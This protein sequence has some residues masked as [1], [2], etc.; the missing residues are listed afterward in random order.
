MAMSGK[1]RL[2]SEFFG[3]IADKTV[4][5]GLMALFLLLGVVLMG[6]AATAGE[7]S[8][9]ENG[10]AKVLGYFIMAFI[11]VDV[12]YLFTNRICR[13]LEWWYKRKYTKS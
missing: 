1:Y 11:L 8:G 13:G 10:V 9:A 12:F 3:R 6:A 5:Y 2:R 7:S 4:F